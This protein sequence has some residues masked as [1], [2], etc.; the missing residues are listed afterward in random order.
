MM[1]NGVLFHCPNKN[2][3]F[4]KRLIE[5]LDMA[6][7]LRSPGNE[8]TLSCFACD[9]RLQ[10]FI[11]RRYKGQR[12]PCFLSSTAF[13]GHCLTLAEIYDLGGGG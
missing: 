9:G 2:L 3:F 12:D 8:S 6:C 7:L 5:P 13:C 1:Y 11:S 10:L 4:S